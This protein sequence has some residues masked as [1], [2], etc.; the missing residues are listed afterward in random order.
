MVHITSLLAKGSAFALSVMTRRATSF[1]STHPMLIK[2][3]LRFAIKVKESVCKGLGDVMIDGRKG[4]FGEFNKFYNLIVFGHRGT[5]G[6]TKSRGELRLKLDAAAL[7]EPQTTIGAGLDAMWGIWYRS[8]E[9]VTDVLGLEN[10]A[11]S[12]K[13]EKAI[14]ANDVVV[15]MGARTLARSGE[16]FIQ[17]H[18]GKTAGDIAGHLTATTAL[19]LT[20]GGF[21][22]ILESL[23]SGV[24]LMV[25]M[26]GTLLSVLGGDILREFT[27]GIMWINDAIG[28]IVAFLDFID[29][30]SCFAVMRPEARLVWLPRVRTVKQKLGMRLSVAVAMK[31]LSVDIEYLAPSM[32]FTTRDKLK[33]VDV[34]LVTTIYDFIEAPGAAIS[35]QVILTYFPEHEDVRSLIQC[36]IDARHSDILSLLDYTRLLIFGEL[37]KAIRSSKLPDDIFSLL[38]EDKVDPMIKETFAKLE[39]AMNKSL[40]EKKVVYT[41][42]E[43]KLKTVTKDLNDSKSR[44]DAAVAKLQAEVAVAKSKAAAATADSAVKK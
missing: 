39:K 36:A 30:E 1:I 2:F 5:V 20:L 19:S 25:G 24:G 33:E 16:D 8:T 43:K 4:F 27:K 15:E 9:A 28:A 14:V 31:S 12:A 38:Y 26:I 23:T 42:L 32:P 29:L 44:T 13:N 18:L 35:L 40:D 10:F 22:G 11:D 41:K 6:V 7:A 34:S 37:N 17:S 21:S 3:V